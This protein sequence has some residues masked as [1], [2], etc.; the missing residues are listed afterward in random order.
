MNLVDSSGWLAF[1]I[2]SANASSFRSPIADKAELIVPTI[3]IFEVAKVMTCER[4]DKAAAAA[5]N[6][7]LDG[8]VVDL[9]AELAL[10]AVRLSLD[11]RL[12]MAD[13]IILATARKFG[14]TLWTQ[15]ADFA[16]LDGVRYL[17]RP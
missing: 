9:D 17:P 4:G 15:D 6:V 16:D 13:S 10:A 2:D 1:F 11:H 14:A 3:A 5:V 8:H 12:P 7:M